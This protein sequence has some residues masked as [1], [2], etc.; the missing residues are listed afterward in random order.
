MNGKTTMKPQMNTDKRRCSGVSAKRRP[1]LRWVTAPQSSLRGAP[2]VQGVALATGD[3]VQW[4]WMHTP[5]GSY[6]S[7]YNIIRRIK[8]PDR[9]PRRSPG[10]AFTNSACVPLR[11]KFTAKPNWPK[12]ETNHG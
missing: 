3:D 10:V 11:Q 7:G 1:V 9:L 2:A 4:L 12:G 6:V 5:N 8:L